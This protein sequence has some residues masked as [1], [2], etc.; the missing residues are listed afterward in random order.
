[1]ADTANESGA[2]D[3]EQALAAAESGNLLTP[4]RRRLLSTVVGQYGLW[5]A[6]LLIPLLI[7]PYI[8]RV[9]GPAGLGL[10][11][12][13]QAFLGYP[14]LIIEYGFVMTG[15][16][17]VAGK[18]NQQ[19]SAAFSRITGAKILLALAAILIMGPVGMWIPEFRASPLLLGLILLG[20]I[21]GGFH[22]EWYFRGRERLMVAAWITVGM[23]LLTIPAILLWVSSPDHV[24]RLIAISVG[25]SVLTTAILLLI[26]GELPRM[27]WPAMKSVY[28]ALKDGG[29]F[30]LILL[31]Q[32]AT[33]LFSPI[34]LKSLTSAQQLGLYYVAARIQGPF[35]G[36]LSPMIIAVFP[37]VVA[38]IEADPRKGTWFA[39]RLSLLVVGLACLAA[40]IIG[41]LAA[42]LVHIFAGSKFE[43]AI[44]TLRVL[45]W[46]IPLVA[47]NTA[48]SNLILMPHRK[49]LT[50]LPVT[51]MATAIVV[52]MSFWLMPRWGQLG[53]AWAMI[54]SEGAK[55][56]MQTL[57]TVWILRGCLGR[58][59]P[60]PALAGDDANG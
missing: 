23:K 21:S 57:S 54:A 12:F 33:S 51:I 50:V 8:A 43:E 3:A 40:V 60:T 56:L 2:A 28:D 59:G 5:G 11:G 35:W 14:T 44:P 53:L 31:S 7:S 29:W 22:P 46:L 30:F 36:L 27:V 34:L 48:T 25:G 32:T 18:S 1:M 4:S 13:C 49:E 16:R 42:P 10:Y 24:T 47:I 39:I 37:R 55:A 9:M 6:N 38:R 20:A 17:A 52:G 58:D 45:S 41:L 26:S 19:V 15:A